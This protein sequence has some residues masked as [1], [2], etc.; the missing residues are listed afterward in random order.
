MFTHKK[1]F[2]CLYFFAPD[3]SH[4]LLSMEMSGGVHD[5]C[6]VLGDVF[7]LIF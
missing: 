2:W 5:I 1:T 7:Y 3:K 6:I 4:C